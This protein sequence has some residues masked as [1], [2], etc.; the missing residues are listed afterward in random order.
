MLLCFRSTTQERRRDGNRVLVAPPQLSSEVRLREAEQQ[1]SYL[2]LK[3]R[4]LVDLLYPDMQLGS[5]ESVDDAVE[6]AIQMLE[7]SRMSD[8]D[9]DL[10]QTEDLLQCEASEDVL[11]LSVKGGDVQTY[12]CRRLVGMSLDSFACH[13]AFPLCLLNDKS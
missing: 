2:R 13:V 1:L 10:P 11:D 12:G 6:Q 3:V 9:D 4:R 5:L 8:A 7:A